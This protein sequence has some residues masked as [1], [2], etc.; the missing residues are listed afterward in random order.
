MIARATTNVGR[1][2]NSNT[3]GARA[4]RSRRD[5]RVFIYYNHRSSELKAR[6]AM[7]VDALESGISTVRQTSTRFKFFCSCIVAFGS[8]GAA[9]CS[10]LTDEPSVGRIGSITL[11]IP[12]AVQG[13]NVVHRDDSDH[14]V[15]PAQ[16][17]RGLSQ[18]RQ[19]TYFDFALDQKSMSVIDWTSLATKSKVLNINAFIVAVDRLGLPTSSADMK[20]RY[21][22]HLKRFLAPP[23]VKLDADQYGLQ[24]YRTNR[25]ARTQRSGFDEEYYDPK[26]NTEILCSRT[27]SVVPPIE[28][29]SACDEIFYIPSIASSA[30]IHFKKT[31]LG[32][33]LILRQAATSFIEKL[34]VKSRT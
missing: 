18:F 21:L 1:S 8:A 27:F 33:W 25:K 17:E 4:T 11:S 30:R 14:V 9:F 16:D 2:K 29:V 23:L 5:R 15:D 19:I 24:A 10:P 6:L 22:D 32:Q 26:T 7:S 12:Q 13:S 28:D 3:G 34:I 20:N 31:Q